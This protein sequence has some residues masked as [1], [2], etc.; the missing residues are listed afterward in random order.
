M[1]GPV[2]LDFVT[3]ANLEVNCEFYFQLNVWQ[4]HQW[5]HFYG[6]SL[7]VTYEHG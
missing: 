4:K 2:P 3:A 1:A 7:A 6:V 5:D